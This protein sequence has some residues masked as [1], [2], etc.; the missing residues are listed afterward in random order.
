M[1][2]NDIDC[3]HEKPPVLPWNVDSVLL[4]VRIDYFKANNNVGDVAFYYLPYLED[5]LDNVNGL[6]VICLKRDRE[7]TVESYMKK[8]RGRNHW[9]DHEGEKWEK[10]PVWDKCYPNYNFE[11]K[12]RAIRE[13]WHEYYDYTEYLSDIYPERVK[14]Y[15]LDVLNNEEVQKKMFDF[16][17]VDEPNLQV[18]LKK[19][20]S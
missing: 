6:K 11:S 8:T 12:E 1:I 20:E 15:S 18:G 17:G 7:E 2:E 13:Y 5:L 10:D 3:K 19:N 9:L 4:E 14:V 16:I